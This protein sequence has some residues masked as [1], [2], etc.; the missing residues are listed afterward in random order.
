[1]KRLFVIAIATVATFA[2]QAQ[3]AKDIERAAFKRDSVAGVLA[4]YRANYAR[5]EEQQ[6]KQLAPA[7]LTLERELALLQADY[8]R[9]VEVVSARDVKAALVEYDQAKLQP[10][11]AEK[12]KTGVAGEAKS[13]YV[14]DA[15][16]LKRNLV[17]NDYFVERLSASDYKSLS[18]A[19]QREVVVKAAVENQTKRYGELLALQRQYME[20]PTREEAD[21]LAKQFAAKV[22]Q[23]AECDNEITSM[24]SSLYYNKMYAY[25]LIMERNGNTPMLDFSAEGTARAE[26]EVNENSDL[27]QSD[28][29][30]GYYA[31]KKALI[32]YELQLASMLS[33][34]TSRDSLKVVAAELKNRDYR[35]SKLSLQRRSFIHYE[36]IEVKKTPFYTSK[37]PVPRTK[38][39]DFGVIYR[40]R[41]GLFTNRPN[42]SALRGVVPLSYTDAYNKGM[43]AYFVGGFRTEQEAKEGVTYLKKLGFR[44]PIVAVWVDGEYYPT[45]EDMH[46]SQSQYNLEISGVATLTEDMKAK[47]LSHKSDC[48]ISRI[49]SNFVIGTFEGKSSAEAVASDLRAMSGEISVKIVKKQ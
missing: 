44:D 42:I 6:R 31:R 34:T 1:M 40:I 3:S 36:D 8:E 23:I 45:L 5:E 28:A 25:D 48:T 9:V 49:G 35:L 27:Y 2:A 33:L 4:D 17:A 21:R 24:W 13:S 26:R 15:N 19:Q 20:A 22:A 18:D 38:V 46:R 10:K 16:R 37:N 41:I 43:Y 39:Y 11:A 47:I 32:E 30:V 12:S 7:I 29:L 14:P